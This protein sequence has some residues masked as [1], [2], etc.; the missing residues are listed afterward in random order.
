MSSLLL[1][2]QMIHSMFPLDHPLN[3]CQKLAQNQNDTLSCL[4]HQMIAMSFEWCDQLVRELSMYS[5]DS[6]HKMCY[7][8]RMILK[9]HRS[10]VVFHHMLWSKNNWKISTA[11]SLIKFNGNIQWKNSVAEDRVWWNWI[12]K[13]S[14]VKINSSKQCLNNQVW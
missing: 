13:I 11:I 1:V 9:F 5:Q 3:Y 12:K 14:K 10:N 4:Q 2:V 7:L 8:H 6:A